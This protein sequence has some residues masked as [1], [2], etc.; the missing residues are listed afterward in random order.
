MRSD[1]VEGADFHRM[2]F[3]YLDQKL[4]LC[5]LDKFCRLIVKKEFLF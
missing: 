5:Y 2:Q 3:G 1:A 4:L